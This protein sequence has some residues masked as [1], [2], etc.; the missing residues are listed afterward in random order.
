MIT[1]CE[2]AKLQDDY[3]KLVK[4]KKLSKKAICD[5]CTPFRDK[6]CISDLQTLQIARR[7]LTLSEILKICGINRLY[8]EVLEKKFIEAMLELNFFRNRYYAD[9]S[10]SRNYKLAQAINTVL[11][12]FAKIIGHQ[13]EK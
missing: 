8:E 11:P 6:A 13:N 9:S 2:I 1:I 4:N 10:T 5:L 7:E 3:E 12:V